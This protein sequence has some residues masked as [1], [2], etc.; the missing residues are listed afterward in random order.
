MIN[1]MSN[2]FNIFNLFNIFNILNIP[3]ILNILNMIVIM[4]M[5]IG[6]NSVSFVDPVLSYDKAAFRH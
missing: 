2:I 4:W 6:S 3:N 5:Q 1:D